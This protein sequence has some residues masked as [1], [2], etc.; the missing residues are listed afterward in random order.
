[1]ISLDQ[2]ELNGV[3]VKCCCL[4]VG[5]LARAM[6]TALNRNIFRVTGHL[7]GEFTGPRWLPRIPVNSP[8]KGQWRGALMFFLIWP[9]INGRVNNG[10]AGDLRRHR[11]HNDVTVMHQSNSWTIDD[12]S[13]DFRYKSYCRFVIKGHSIT[14]FT[15]P[16]KILWQMWLNISNQNGM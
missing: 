10:E 4:S 16:C 1:M 6:L 3:N 8:H 13:S 12:P 14:A 7:C 9:R 2:N 5:R 15:S 11:D